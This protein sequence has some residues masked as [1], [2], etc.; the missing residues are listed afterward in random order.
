MLVKARLTNIATESEVEML[1]QGLKDSCRPGM[2][3]G[4]RVPTLM[5][6]CSTGTG[7]SAT[8][9]SPGECERRAGDSAQWGGRGG[10]PEELSLW[11]M[12]L[13]PVCSGLARL[14]G[15]GWGLHAALLSTCLED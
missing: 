2:A 13:T 6:L 3:A 15:P 10:W 14:W 1:E 9:P 12:S 4:I 5:P 7:C 8:N 11:A